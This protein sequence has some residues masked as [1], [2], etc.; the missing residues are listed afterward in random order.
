MTV[1]R[2]TRHDEILDRSIDSAENENV[3][4]ARHVVQQKR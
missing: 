4:R 1:Q 2:V 3:P